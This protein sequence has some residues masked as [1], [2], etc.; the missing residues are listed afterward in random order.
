MATEKLNRI[1]FFKMTGAGNDFVFI[2]NRDGAIDADGNPVKKTASIEQ[3][4]RDSA[5]FVLRG[6]NVKCEFKIAED[7]WPV[8]VDEG[9]MNQVINNLIINADQAM[10][11][12]GIIKVA[13]ENQIIAPLN[14]MSLKEGRYIKISI[15]DHGFGIPADH[16]HKIF[17]PYFTTKEHGSGLGL[18]TVYSIVKNHDGFVGVLSKEGGGASFFV[19]LPSSENGPG[20]VVASDP[21]TISGTGRILVMD[22]EE[23]IRDVATDILDYLGYAAVACRDGKEAIDLYREAMTVG[24]PFAAVLMDLTIP[25]GM[26]GRETIQRLLEIDRHAVGVVSSGYCND[27]ILSNYRDYGFSGIVEKPY[28]LDTLGKVLHDLLG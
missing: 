16:M 5:A 14:E 2:D 4:V 24:E 28:S 26:G 22:D 9:Q 3:I 12:G 17:D 7:V 19:Y 18:A 1:H 10:E 20:E 15:D 25:G 11:S 8:E 13:I 27:P 6:S 23:L 21:D